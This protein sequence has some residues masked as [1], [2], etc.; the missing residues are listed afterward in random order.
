MYI[1]NYPMRYFIF[2]FS[3]VFYLSSQGK[4]MYIINVNGT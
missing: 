4:I 3:A 1:F 2:I